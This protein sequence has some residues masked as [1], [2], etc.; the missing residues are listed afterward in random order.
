MVTQTDLIMAT[1]TGLFT[2]EEALLNMVIR[3]EMQTMAPTSMNTVIGLKVTN[4]IKCNLNYV[5]QFP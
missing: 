1:G 2:M 4:G 3:A 5:A